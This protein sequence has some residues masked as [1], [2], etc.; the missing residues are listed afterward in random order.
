MPG[1]F[2]RRR[3]LEKKVRIAPHLVPKLEA[4]HKQHPGKIPNFAA[5]VNYVLEIAVDAAAADLDECAARVGQILIE[6]Q[7]A[8]GPGKN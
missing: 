5:A 3:I 8:S 7:S 6:D 2:W 4:L 1:G